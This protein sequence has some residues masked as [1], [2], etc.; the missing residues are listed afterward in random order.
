MDNAQNVLIAERNLFRGREKKIPILIATLLLIAGIIAIIC[1]RPDDVKF[2]EHLYNNTH[3]KVDVATMIGPPYSLHPINALSGLD[4]HIQ[5]K[6]AETQTF[7]YSGMEESFNILK[8]IIETDIVNIPRK[9]RGL[10]DS[11]YTIVLKC[12]CHSEQYLCFNSGL[13]E[14][15]IITDEESAPAY[16]IKNTS[17]FKEYLEELV[18]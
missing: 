7:T 4:V 14:I 16:K 17:A 3:E 5:N 15:W 9:E 2:V 6:D 1:Q 18:K 11:V 12:E 13:S 8:K 10:E